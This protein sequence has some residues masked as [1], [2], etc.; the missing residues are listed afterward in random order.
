MTI[1]SSKKLTF[2][3]FLEQCPDGSGRYE[4]VDGELVKVE[5]TRAHKNIARFLVR[6]FDRESE[7]LNLD[8]IID[9]DIIVKTVTQEG[10]ERGRNPDVGVVKSEVWNRN[11]R[12]YG[13]LTEP[14]E[15]A[16]EVV[17]TNWEDDYLDRRDEYRRLGI[18]EY[19][20]VDYL[21][22]ASRTFLGNPKRPQILVYRLV[23]GEYQLQ[24]FLGGDRILSPTF[25]E[26]ELTVDE[27]FASSGIREL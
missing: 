21:A 3:E 19:W 14:I 2:A 20:I 25:P 23:E 11:V 13:A 15:L 18:A 12:T 27:V 4:L 9:K 16:V 24:S 5:P 17:S 22:I 6:R 8:Y 7:R 10:E 26:L 1:T